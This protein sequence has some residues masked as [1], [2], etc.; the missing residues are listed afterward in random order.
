[1]RGLFGRRVENEV[2]AELRSHIE[3]RID[4]N[5]KAG[6]SP[7]EARRDAVRRFGNRTWMKEETRRADILPWLETDFAGRPLRAAAVP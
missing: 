7:D 3:M 1:L 2:E 4:M 5:M 6:M